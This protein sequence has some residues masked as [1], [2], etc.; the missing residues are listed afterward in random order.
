MAHNHTSTSERWSSPLC[1]KHPLHAA[2]I[3][4]HCR[5]RSRS[6]Q[7]IGVGV[8]HPSSAPSR[9]CTLQEL[10]HLEAS[11]LA[12]AA[13][14]RRGPGSQSFGS[15]RVAA[16]T[17]HAYRSLDRH[18]RPACSCALAD[19]SDFDTV[20][21][22]LSSRTRCRGHNVVAFNSLLVLSSAFA[23]PPPAGLYLCSL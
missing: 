15:E 9:A 19:A 6:A 18:H 8:T 20:L 1:R 2:V 22:D 14:G 13:N 10:A 7:L 11:A 5:V 3:P 12:N 17:R 21:L 4:L 16:T 23:S